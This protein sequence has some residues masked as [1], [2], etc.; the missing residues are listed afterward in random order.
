MRHNDVKRGRKE[1][2]LIE[3]ASSEFGIESTPNIERLSVIVELYAFFM[4]LK[5]F[6]N[7]IEC[8]S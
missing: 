4:A 8:V 2:F 7:E 3:N 6:N 1:F 5:V